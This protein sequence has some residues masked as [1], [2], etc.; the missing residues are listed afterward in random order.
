VK[1]W[2]VIIVGAGIIGLSLAISL[3]KQGLRVLV[4]ER[5]EPGREASSAAAGMLSPA[6]SEIPDALRDIAKKSYRRY[7][8]FI[9]ELQDESGIKVDFREHGTILL[10]NDDNFPEAAEVI[11][12]DK[13]RSLEPEIFG[14]SV[15]S[16]KLNA[17]FIRER[18]VDPRLLVA[19]VI[20]AARHRDVDISSGTEVRSIEGAQGRT[21]GV[22]TDKTSYGA[23]MVVN[24]AGAWA[25]TIGP[26][27]FPVHPVKGQMLALVQGLALRHVVRS[28]K[29]YVVPRS[30]GRLVIGST[31]ENVGYDKSV[32]VNTIQSFLH[33]AVELLPQLQKAKQHEVWAGLRPGTPDHLPIIGETS[34]RGFFAA[35]GH[36]RDGIL[37]APITAD[38]MTSVVLGR[39]PEVDITNFAPARFV[40]A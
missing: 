23:G 4:V 24:C 39:A 38:V 25:G 11:S 18:T 12:A 22:R 20:Q 17:A 34:T 32:S 2:D 19:A 16:G 36:Y 31:L 9:H 33:S 37:L 27:A 30:D 3:R 6:G 29:I 5:G 26:H 35:T 10:S 8:E 28:E 21:V 1:T 15:S 13:L 7:P 14:E 40:F